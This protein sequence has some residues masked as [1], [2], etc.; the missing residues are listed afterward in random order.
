[1][2]VIMSHFA[3]Q[4][5]LKNNIKELKPEVIFI[6]ETKLHRK[7]Q[8]KLENYEVFEQIRDKSMGGGLLIAAHKSIEPVL[9]SEGDDNVELLT[10]QCNLGGISARFLTG[11]GPQE[12]ENYQK[13]LEFYQRLDEQCQNAVNDDC[14]I[15]IELDANAKID[16]S[17]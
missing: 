7:G 15:V 10:V 3:C 1:M 9:I 16:K 4:L 2:F 13:R 5:S 6:Q 12:S 11:Y 14:G 8:I 17:A